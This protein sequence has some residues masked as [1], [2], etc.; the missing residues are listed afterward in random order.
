VKTKPKPLPGKATRIHRQP[1]HE[2]IDNQFCFT[3][4]Q[5]RD[6]YG[7]GRTAYYNEVNEG[8][9]ALKK[10]GNLRRIAKAEAERWWNDLEIIGRNGRAA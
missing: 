10:I 1:T 8:R 4:R 7:I 9:L 2:E 6:R 5:F 3:P